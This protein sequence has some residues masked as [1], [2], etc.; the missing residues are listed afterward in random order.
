MLRIALSRGAQLV[1]EK[2]KAMFRFLLATAL[3]TIAISTVVD[4]PAYAAGSACKVH[5]IAD[6]PQIARDSGAIGTA[7]VMVTLSNGNVEKASIAQSSGNHWLD[8]AALRAASD[9]RFTG[10]C[11]DG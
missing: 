1:H 6:A 4:V 5:A 2:E 3:A 8:L 11:E 7:L 9:A 10:D